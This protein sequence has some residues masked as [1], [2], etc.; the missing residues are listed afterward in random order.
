M[1]FA[2]DPAALPIGN[3]AVCGVNALGNLS[4]G[5][6]CDTADD[7]RTYKCSQ[8]CSTSSKVGDWYQCII[9]VGE[10][11]GTIDP[12]RVF[13]QSQVRANNTV[14]INKSFAS[15]TASPPRKTY[16]FLILLLSTFLIGTASAEVIPSLAGNLVARQ[17]QPQTSC[18]IQ[19]VQ[20]YR[21]FRSPFQVAPAF[22]NCNMCDQIADIQPGIT[23][24][25]RT[26]NDTSAAEPRYDAFFDLLANR[27]S[28]RFPAMSSVELT[29][30][31]ISQ[32]T[33][34]L[35]LFY[36]RVSQSLGKHG[37]Y[38]MVADIQTSAASTQLSLAVAESSAT[39]T[40]PCQFSPAA[41]SLLRSL[42]LR[43]TSAMLWSKPNLG[44][45]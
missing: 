7:L 14:T 39:P 40:A 27:T 1:Q 38:V 13:C 43:R 19:I 15:L 45:S 24:N 3:G 41:R 26:I 29:Y 18:S 22:E 12:S 4:F 9:K 44:S 10:N 31:Y 32:G 42:L 36:G 16:Y 2:V 20:D 25:N 30:Q 28:H 5:N 23:N 34:Y 11:N 21:T 35:A 33:G 8:Y 6:C 17:S 37:K